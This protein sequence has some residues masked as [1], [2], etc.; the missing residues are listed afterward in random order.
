MLCF[1]LFSCRTISIKN[2]DMIEK[3]SN[4]KFQLT[5]K[6]QDAL[7]YIGFGWTGGMGSM[8]VLNTE[9]DR[10]KRFN[11]YPVF[12]DES[13]E[14]TIRVKLPD[15][16]IGTPT[17]KISAKIILEKRSGINY[18]VESRPKRTY[19]EAKVIEFKDINV[20]AEE[21]DDN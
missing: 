15:C 19:Y 20:Q 7:F 21:C 16:Y 14:D 5:E 17:I 6:T 1:L 10:P 9:T 8:P 2:P 4:E 13:Y 12:F 3:N 18:S 11:D